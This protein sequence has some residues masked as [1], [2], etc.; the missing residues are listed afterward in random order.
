MHGDTI[1]LLTFVF[2][3][4]AAFAGGLVARALHLP[5]I[6]GYLL[7]GFAVGPFTPGFIGDSH[8]MSQLSE[9]GVMFM[10]FG[11]GMHFSIRDL[12]SV[13]G[14]AIPG[15]VLQIA[16]G[17]LAGWGLAQALGWS[18]EAGIM[19]GLSVSI[20]STVVL[21]RNLTDAGRYQ[22]A[23]GRVATG[24]LIVED[25]ATIVILVILPVV[26]GPG[27]VAGPALAF[28]VAEALVLTAAFVALML[29]VGSR[30]LPWLLTK[31]ARFCPRELFQLAVVVVALGV[32]MVA[33]LVF[34]VSVALGAF[35]A[36][37]VV[38][39]SA[40]SHRI[41]A[42]AVPFQDLFSIIFFA[43]VG[44]MVDPAVLVAHLGELIAI[45]ALIM[46][47]KWLINMVL[48]IVLSAG[49]GTTLTVAAG[50]SQIGEFSFII[51]QLGVSLGVLTQEQ[52]SL[53]LG[54][55]VISIALNSFVFKSVDPLEHV[56]GA[57]PLFHKLYDRRVRTIETP[58]TK[59]LANHVVVVGYGHAGRCVADVLA[60]LDIPCLVVERAFEAAEEAEA[61]GL[62]VLQGDAANSTILE[63][64]RLDAA[65][66]LVVAIDQEASAE[67][68][69]RE[70]RELAPGLTVVARADSDGA[71]EALV[72]A[73]AA[74]VVRPELEGG[75]ELMRHA[76]LR[77]G[78][79]PQQIQGYAN[80]LRES[81]YEALGDGAQ[82][83]RVRAV[84]R[85]MTAMHDLEL[86][87]VEVEE[88]SAL[89]GTTLAESD[90]RAR[91]GAQ[92]VAL[93]RGEAVTLAVAPNEVLRAGD[94]LGLMASP[95]GLSAAERELAAT[96]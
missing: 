43:S 87:W 53:I 37:V 38:S 51:G 47:G 76:L 14:I 42:E 55:A 10:M 54:G 75:I 58:G 21:I 18:S 39:G 49:L 62:M 11:V 17:T 81:G 77:L 67:L 2:A 80:D 45:V 74:D 65:R 61:A 72:E 89:A 70:A 31:I 63:H 40:L 48:G 27:E 83:A 34:N 92:V 82:L 68:V 33:S 69:A 24:W 5:P 19:L 26:F 85:L 32:A 25:L 79:R 29:V 52:Y 78:Y 93:R 94:V 6:V 59:M 44:M 7:G 36:G 22:S 71:V 16:L 86:D 90:L 60:R 64:A 12:L 13:K 35:L 30:V 96:S 4:V 50:L 23:G 3:L 66:L 8:A 20:A 57:H 88:G 84:E 91:T 1:L 46:V 73:G 15:A 95:E 28:E 41:A 9:V 56:L